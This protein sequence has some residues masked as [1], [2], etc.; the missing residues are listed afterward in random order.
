MKIIGNR[1]ALDL[2]QKKIGPRAY[3]KRIGKCFEIGRKYGAIGKV[4]IDLSMGVGKS[5]EAAL[6]SAGVEIPAR[7]NGAEVPTPADIAKM[8]GGGE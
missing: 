2:A 3:V 8:A 6:R 5:W 4:Q 1:E 7:V